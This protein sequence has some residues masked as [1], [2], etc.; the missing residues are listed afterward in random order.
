MNVTKLSGWILLLLAAVYLGISLMDFGPEYAAAGHIGQKAE[1]FGLKTTDT[2]LRFTMGW[3]FVI[4]ILIIGV[5]CVAG[6]WLTTQEVPQF[7]WIGA[8]GLFFIFSIVVRATPVLPIT[9]SRLSPGGAFY[10]AQV[11]AVVGSD[12]TSNYV[13]VTRKEGIRAVTT[14]SL[15]GQQQTGPAALRLNDQTVAG[16]Y[17]SCGLPLTVKGTVTGTTTL[18]YE[19]K[20][21]TVPQITVTAATNGLPQAK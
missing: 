15:N 8:I 20:V 1:Q 10:G 21:L 6:W 2:N 16:Q 17:A 13:A 3:E 9:V 12:V 14:L 19:N 7:I 4:Y 5:M 18:A 11:E